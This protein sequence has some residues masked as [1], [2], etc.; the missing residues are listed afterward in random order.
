MSA[1]QLLHLSGVVKTFPGQVA[2]ADADLDVGAGEIHALVGQNGSGKST[3]IKLLAG[4]HQPDLVRESTIAGESFTLGSTS[5]A[6][7]LG[8]RFIHQNLGLIEGMSVVENCALTRGF[9]TGKMWRINWSEEKA[10]VAGLLERWGVEVDVGQPIGHLAPAQRTMVA[11]VRA[12]QDWEN[13]ARLLVLDEPT[14]TLPA[15]EVERL[16]EVVHRVAAAGLGVLFVSHRLDEVFDVA[17]RVTVFRDGK[18][19]LSQPTSELNHTTLVRAMLGRSIAAWE[20]G[21]VHPGAE[22]A[23]VVENLAG[24]DL[25]SLSLTVRKGEIVGLA[26]LLGS[27][28]DEVAPLISGAI[29]RTGGTVTAGT[30]VVP[31]GKPRASL[32]AGVATVPVD[33]ARNGAVP[34]FSVEENIVLPRLGPLVR[35]G[36]ISGRLQRR[37]STDWI[38]QLDIRPADPRKAFLN[39]S[40][41]NQQKVVLAKCLRLAPDVLL[42][43]EPTQGVDVGAK[44]AL[45][46][47]VADRAAE[48]LAVLVSSGDSEELARLCHRV[49]VLVNGEVVQEISGAD[50]TPEAIDLAVLRA[51]EDEVSNV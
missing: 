20:T 14:A 21:E 42:L 40:G 49:V 6:D 37:Q 27:G 19:V 46:T 44:V 12:L 23:L 41:G 34:S 28:R 16:F 8:M 26:G 33:R 2:L 9:P 10:R 51:E 13:S 25:K 29:E 11:I 15:A 24:I 43:D 17:G 35:G 31:G 45:Y 36:K 3:M 32:Q 47:I 5:E 30:S 4:Y 18:T 39:L 22:S 1:D 38:E 48:G 7:R 50:L